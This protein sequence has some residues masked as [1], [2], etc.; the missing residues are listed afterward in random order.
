M[1]IALWL[2]AVVYVAG[3]VFNFYAMT[4]IAPNATLGLMLLRSAVW[5]VYWAT[6][7]PQGVRLD[8]DCYPPDD[9]ECG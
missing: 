7:W 1:K 8:V 6:G 3:F 4:Q 5:P 2:V 9:P